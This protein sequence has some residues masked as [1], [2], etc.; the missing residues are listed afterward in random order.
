[1]SPWNRPFVILVIRLIACRRVAF[2][3]EVRI[4]GFLSRLH[5]VSLHATRPCCTSL[6]HRPA[7]LGCR[8]FSTQRKAPSKLLGASMTG[9]PKG[10]EGALGGRK[11]LLRR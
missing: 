6:R 7:T 5:D 3:S 11:P 10:G 2:Q 8:Y 9:A 1:M 4:C